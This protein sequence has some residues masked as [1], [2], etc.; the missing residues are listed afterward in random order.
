MANERA[1]QIFKPL[2][3]YFEGN[4]KYSLMEH[5]CA[6]PPSPIPII[7]LKPWMNASGSVKR[8]FAIGNGIQWQP[9]TD[10]AWLHSPRITL[11]S[12]TQRQA[13]YTAYTLRAASRGRTIGEWILQM[14]EQEQ[15]ATS[16]DNDHK[17]D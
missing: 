6:S 8:G 2:E 15:T 12:C 5:P 1:L 10:I 13:F 3:T 16:Q 4:K 14:Q 7:S 9:I 11:A 17:H